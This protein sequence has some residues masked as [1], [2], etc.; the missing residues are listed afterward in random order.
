MLYPLANILTLVRGTSKVA[1]PPTGT[2]EPAQ[3]GVLLPRVAGMGSKGPAVTR[4]L[5]QCLPEQRLP[6]ERL[7]GGHLVVAADA[8]N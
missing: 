8:Y 6:E 7:S 2:L 1:P 4:P 5:V 3:L